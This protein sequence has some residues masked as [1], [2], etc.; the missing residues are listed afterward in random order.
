[1][2]TTFYNR[3]TG[4]E[5]AHRYSGGATRGVVVELRPGAAR[6]L[7]EDGLRGDDGSTETLESLAE[8]VGEGR[9]DDWV[10]RIARGESRTLTDHIERDGVAEAH[11]RDR[12]PS[13]AGIE[14]ALH[15]IGEELHLANLARDER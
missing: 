12:A 7:F 3:K 15:R 2:A 6:V 4:E 10:E 11:R 8:Q 9:A 14:D 13:L 1:M 5:C